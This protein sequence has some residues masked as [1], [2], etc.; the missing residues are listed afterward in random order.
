MKKLITSTLFLFCASL[1]IAQTATDDYYQKPNTNFLSKDKVSGSIS[2][3]TGFSFFNSSKNGAFTTF[4]APKIGYQLTKKFKLNVGLMHYTMTGNAF[5]PLNQ[6]EALLNNSNKSISGN[7][8]FVEGQYQLNKKLMMSGSVMYN[9]T[10]SINK[11]NNFKAV[12]IGMDYKLTEHTS[13]G[14]RA[15]ISQ[16]NN[17]PY[18]NNRMGGTNV[19]AYPMMQDMFGTGFGQDFHSPGAMIR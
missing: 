13:I 7:L 2:M 10:P 19:G 15:S 16:G 18:Y 8:L 1:I 14:I 5:M 4:I 11:N 3:G 6:N 12:A 9:A 17:S